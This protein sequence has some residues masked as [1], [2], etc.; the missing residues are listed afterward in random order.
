VVTREDGSKQWALRGKPLYTFVK[1]Q[2][3]GDTNGINVANVWRLAAYMPGVG[4]PRPDG[5]G[6]QVVPA[7]N[8]P[9]LVDS[10]GK[11]LYVPSGAPAAKSS[12]KETAPAAFM[13]L[14]APQLANAVGDFTAVSAPDGTRQW[15]Y[16][17]KALFTYAGDKAAGD[18]NGAEADKQYQVARL[19]QYFM[20]KGVVVRHDPEY[21]VLFANAD[22]KTLYLRDRHRYGVGGHN[23]ADSKPIP[24]LGRIMGTFTC[25]AECAKTWPPLLASDS[26]QPSGNWTIVQRMDGAKQ[27]AYQGYPLY[28]YTGD[29]KPGDATG[30]DLFTLID[31]ANALYWRTARP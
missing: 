6:V 4:L 10:Q 5:I 24:A 25:D 30:N 19:E 20:P 14:P 1:D 8:G 22:G 21:G 3:V 26:D 15:A 12:G 31:G 13:P 18:A 29:S 7:A 16:K 17:G 27:W 9:A 28:A 23:T 2:K 11:T